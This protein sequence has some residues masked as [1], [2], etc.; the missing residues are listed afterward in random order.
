[1][2]YN[3]HFDSNININLYLTM[4]YRL[5]KLPDS[6]DTHPSCPAMESVDTLDSTGLAD[7]DRTAPLGPHWDCGLRH[8]GHY[9]TS[10]FIDR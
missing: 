3:W 7:S 9:Y 4:R 8:T 5:G 6:V 2:D 1:M 10:L